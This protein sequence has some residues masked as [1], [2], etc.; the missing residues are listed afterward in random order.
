VDHGELGITDL[1]ASLRLVGKF[2]RFFHFY[3]LRI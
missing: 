1:I 3:R 2:F